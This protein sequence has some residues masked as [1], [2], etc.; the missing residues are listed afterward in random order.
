[1]MQNKVNKKYNTYIWYTILFAV[2]ATF[3]FLSF[4]LFNKSFIWEIDG[5]LQHYTYIVKMKHLLTDLLNHGEFSFWSWDIGLGADTI[6]NLAIVLCDPFAYI[7]AA[8][9]VEYID[10]GYN[11]SIVLR[12]YVAGLTFLFFVNSKKIDGKLCVAGALGY[13]FSNWAIGASVHAFFLNPLWL[14]PIIILGVE[15]VEEKKSPLLLIGSVFLALVTSV[16]FAIMTAIMVFIYLI[17]RFI[18]ETADKK[19]LPFLQYMGKYIGYVLVSVCLSTIVI[20]PVISTLIMAPK[21]AGVPVT[22]FHSV[23]TYVNFLGTL[24]NGGEVYGNYS[25]IGLSAVFVITIPMMVYNIYKKKSTTAM[26]VCIVMLF[27]NLTPIF[28]SMFNGFSYSVGRWCYGLTFFFVWAAIQCISE[29]MESKNTLIHKYNMYGFLFLIMV[30]TFVI[31]KIIFNIG[32]MQSLTI[33]AIN[34]ICGLVAVFLIFD[35][36]SWK[37]QIRSTMILGLVVINL[38]LVWNIKFSVNYGDAL[39]TRMYNG[40][41]YEL[42]ENSPQKAGTLIKDNS[43]Y[44]IDQ[45]QSSSLS[46][47]SNTTVRTPINENIYFGNKSIYSYFSTLNSKWFD[48]NKVVANSAGYYRRICTFSND[49]RTRLDFLLGVKYF[50]GDYEYAPSNSASAYV[51]YGYEKFKELAKTQVLKNKYNIGLGFVYDQVISRSEFERYSPLEREQILM[52][53]AVVE[54]DVYNEIIDPVNR[55]TVSN[56]YPVN[57]HEYTIVRTSGVEFTKNRITVKEAN[58]T[59]TIKVPEIKNSEL[60]FSFENLIRV[61]YT[62]EELFEQKFGGVDGFAT[63]KLEQYKF[64][65]QYMFYKPFNN[66]ALDIYDGNK[67]KRALNPAGENQAFTDLRNFLV[68]FGYYDQYSGEVT[69]RFSETGVY[70]FDRIAVLSVPIAGFE[71]SAA[72]A[73]NQKYNM[74]E[75]Y[76]NY[77]KGTID[78]PTEGVLYLSILENPGWKVYI[79]GEEVKQTFNVNYGFTGVSVPAGN[80]V[81]ELKYRP[82]GFAISVVLTILG[83]GM[84][85]FISIMH[86]RKRKNS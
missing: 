25:F 72:K 71:T 85:V 37:N 41:M 80:H 59:I 68:N 43:F 5:Y 15:R 79:D 47:I 73:M 1:M 50:L 4:I 36:I 78:N 76:S 52:D 44:R 29:V 77:V 56:T 8:F 20:L 86:V 70:T 7:A 66:F 24:V 62:K 18:K 11:I 51:A 10:I 33:S 31:S 67:V 64:N 65:R 35:T 6:G 60:Y 54:D 46:G 74:E 40:Q 84:V 14:F 55:D 28:G 75:H 42:L 81:V 30:V 16:Y 2:T 27:M 23:K 12:L 19:V 63:S 38:I 53:Y 34:L 32:S 17:V 13:A 83:L 49:N 45:V 26:I 61:P 57:E 22:V 48:F 21:D 69:I 9:P 39:D 82:V 58:G 3:V